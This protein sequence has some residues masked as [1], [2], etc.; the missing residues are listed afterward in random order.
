MDYQEEEL[1]N[2]LIADGKLTKEKYDSLKIESLTLGKS[3]MQLLQDKRLIKDE[4]IARAKAKYL[5]IPYFSESRITVSPDLLSMINIDLAKTYKVMPLTLDKAIGELTLVMEKPEDLSVVDFFHKRT[6]YRVKSMMTSR[7]NLENLINTTYSQSLTGEISGVL[8][9]GGAELGEEEGGV[10]LVTAD[11]IS[12]IIKEPKIVEIVRKVLEYA[13]RLRASDIHIEPQENITRVRFRIDGILEEKLTLDK[14]YHAALISRIKILSGMKID[15]KRVPQDGRFNF[16]SEYGEVDLRIS[17]LPTVNGEKIVMR[18]LKKS[19]KVPTLGDL[20]LRAKALAVLEEAIRIP[21]G[22]ILATG[23]TGSGKTTTLYALLTIINTPKVNIVTL[24]DPV[25]YQMAG[26]NQVQI[27]P[28]AGLTFASGLRSFLRQ[29]PNI[30]MVGEIRDEETAQLAIQAS[31]TGHLVFST[32]HTNSAAGALPRLLDMGAEPF[33]LASSMT[34]AIGQ[35]VLRKICDNCKAPY[36]PDPKVIEDMKVVLGSMF[37]GWK[38]SNVE[39]IKLAVQNKTE[40]MIYKGMG[41]EKCNHS[42]YLGR[43]GIY[44][45]LRVTEKI[46]KK[47]LERADAASVEKAAM[48]DGMIIMKQDGY[49]KVLD[50]VTTIEEVIRVAQV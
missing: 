8:K 23:P 1:I 11:T 48:E 13:V 27:N 5:N 26:V 37:E 4:D 29:D 41:C 44:E 9:R 50:G 42:G 25:E 40:V 34:A 21:H 19:E 32:V 30:I 2:T 43:I 46:A 22:I 18:L 15:E 31:L 33:L 20:G 35:R 6:G 16:S 45:V 28:Q 10:R 7:E 3:V 14:E 36:V 24:E 49:L 39:K 17:S 12:Q 38:K 47:I